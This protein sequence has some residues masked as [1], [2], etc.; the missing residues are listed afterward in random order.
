MEIFLNRKWENIKKIGNME[1]LKED[2]RN[3]KGSIVGGGGGQ[4]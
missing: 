2:N 1:N 4:M 3:K